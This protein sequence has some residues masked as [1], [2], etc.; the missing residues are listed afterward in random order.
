MQLDIPQICTMVLAIILFWRSG[1][2]MLEPEF[3]VADGADTPPEPREK[4]KAWEDLKF[5]LE[6]MRHGHRA[7]SAGTT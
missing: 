3:V 4:R 2:T 5:A 7:P 6:C 1:W